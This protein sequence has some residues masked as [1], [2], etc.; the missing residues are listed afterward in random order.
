MHRAHA[1]CIARITRTIS[2]HHASFVPHEI[3]LL[4]MHAALVSV[5]TTVVSSAAFTV[6]PA[7]HIANGEASVVTCAK[8]IVIEA[9]VIVA[10]LS[11]IVIGAA[12]IAASAASIAC[13]AAD[14][15][16]AT[17]FYPFRSSS[18]S[19]KEHHPCEQ[20]A[21]QAHAGTPSTGSAS[22]VARRSSVIRS[23]PSGTSNAI[24]R[25]TTSKAQVR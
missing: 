11:A 2:L 21:P 5:Q 12:P 15:V 22:G 3:P 24:G 8:L 20:P 18:I 4:R 25:M 6:I 17:P 7:A 10:S 16:S 1:V 9:A 23:S 13:H 14:I 19:I